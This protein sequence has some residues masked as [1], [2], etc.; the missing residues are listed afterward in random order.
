M[1]VLY[2]QK[3]NNFKQQ[4]NYLYSID[5]VCIRNHTQTHTKNK[6]TKLHNKGM[7]L[8]KKNSVSLNV[9]PWY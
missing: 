1:Y 6:S 7:T 5:I 4:R 2:K 8:D 9:R 3:Q